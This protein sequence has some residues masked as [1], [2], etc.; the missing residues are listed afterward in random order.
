M[1]TDA[2][3]QNESEKTR[4]QELIQ[5]RDAFLLRVYEKS[6]AD[7]SKTIPYSDIAEALGFNEDL[8]EKISSYLEG[9]K[10]IRIT[11]IVDTHVK[12]NGPESLEI[13]SSHRK[14]IAIT[15]K[16]IV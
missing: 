9:E 10:L 7:P 15:H 11:P 14:G 6:A 2:H 8:L 16:G 1:D 12:E 5:Q 4:L 13:F 3:T